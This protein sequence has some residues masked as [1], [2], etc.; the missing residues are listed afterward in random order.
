MKIKDIDNFIKATTSFELTNIFSKIKVQLKDSSDETFTGFEGYE[1][2]L[3][4]LNI[5]NYKNLIQT[6]EELEDNESKFIEEIKSLLD[7]YVH[8]IQECMDLHIKEVKLLAKESPEL[9]KNYKELIKN[10]MG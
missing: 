7:K 10:Q 5:L 3:L 2:C 4:N 8:E 1:L 9:F 6:T